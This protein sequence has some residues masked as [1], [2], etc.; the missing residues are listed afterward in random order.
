MRTMGQL[1][2]YGARG[3]ARDARQAARFF[4]EAARQGDA[5]SM[6]TCATLARPSRLQL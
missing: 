5:H 4:Q 2:Y 3:M 6:V 1:H